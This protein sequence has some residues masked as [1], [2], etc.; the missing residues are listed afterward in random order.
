MPRVPLRWAVAACSRRAALQMVCRRPQSFCLSDFGPCAFG[1]APLTAQARALLRGQREG[2]RRAASGWSKLDDGYFL[3]VRMYV[4]IV[5]MSASGPPRSAASGSVPSCR[6][7]LSSPCPSASPAPCIALVLRRD[8][9]VGRADELLVDRMARRA[10]VLLQQSLGAL[11][12]SSAGVARHRRR[13]AAASRRRRAA[14]AAIFM[15]APRGGINRP[16]HSTGRSDRS[17]RSA[18]GRA[19]RSAA[20][21]TSPGTP[22]RSRLASGA[23]LSQLGRQC[24]TRRQ[25]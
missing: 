21:T 20:G 14:R 10:A 19:W 9:D 2:Y 22:M 6:R 1:G 15:R 4:T 11:R 13:Q 24:L 23:R 8:V 17:S 16:A 25:S 12:L 3:S 18:P 5:L 7:R